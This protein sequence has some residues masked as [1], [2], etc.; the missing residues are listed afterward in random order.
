MARPGRGQDRAQI[1]TF[2]TYR[3]DGERRRTSLKYYGAHRD[4]QHEVEQ[5]RDLDSEINDEAEAIKNE[6]AGVNTELQNIAPRIEL[7]PPDIPAPSFPIN[8]I[9]ART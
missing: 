3:P 6:V 1:E 5:I 8:R 2:P 9:M 7:E 4:P